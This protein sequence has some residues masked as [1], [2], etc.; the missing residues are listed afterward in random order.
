[1]IVDDEPL[2]HNVII[3]Y[4]SDLP[5]LEIC[6][7]A[8]LPAKALQILKTR[9][10]DLV[11][12]DIKMPKMSGLEMLRLNDS[13]P[14]VIVTSAYE[15]HAL[16][17]YELNVCDYLL[18]PFRLDRFI[19][20]TEKALD[21]HKLKYSESKNRK[22][23]IIKSDKKLIPVDSNDILYLESYGN[24]VKVWTI[25]E[26]IVTPRTLYSFE[27]E[28]PSSEFYKTHKSFIVNRSQIEFI[29]GNSIRLKNKMII[30]I[31]KNFKQG[32]LEFMSLH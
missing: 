7:Q 9:P 19:Q 20:A 16:E 3:E 12:L 25:N 26:C 21:N 18:K 8:Y 15:E 23:L 31:S 13:N 32:F 27:D 17:S 28:I 14:E 11:F 6:E 4:A 10:L 29:E 24:Y 30:P 1:M 2:A 22:T 5:Y